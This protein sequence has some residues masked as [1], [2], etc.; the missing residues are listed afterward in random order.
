MTEKNNFFNDLKNKKKF[1]DLGK[2]RIILSIDDR[3]G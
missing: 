2:I 3:F 1:F